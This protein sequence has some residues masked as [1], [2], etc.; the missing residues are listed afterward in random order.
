[1]AAKQHSNTKKS[2]K[3][4]LTM[5]ER[6]AWAAHMHGADPEWLHTREARNL[7]VVFKG[8]FPAWLI[9]SEP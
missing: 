3:R 6:S 1:M 4:V 9:E 2:R 5:S 8:C 7:A